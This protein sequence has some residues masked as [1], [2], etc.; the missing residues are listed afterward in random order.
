MP[1]EVRMEAAGRW[2]VGAIA[3]VRVQSSD[4]VRSQVRCAFYPA[5][6][7]IPIEVLSLIPSVQI[8]TYAVIGENF[9]A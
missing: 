6:I 1:N 3:K 4:E 8:F 2:R 7:E 9:K 5:Q